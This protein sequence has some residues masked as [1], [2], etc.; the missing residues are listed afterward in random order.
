MTTGGKVYASKTVIDGSPPA[1]SVQLNHKS[2]NAFSS[3]SLFS[4]LPFCSHWSCMGWWFPHRPGHRWQTTWCRSY[5]PPW[6]IECV[7]NY[8]ASVKWFNE[9]A[10]KL[11]YLY[12][13]I[14]KVC[15]LVN[16]NQSSWTAGHTSLS[17]A[18]WE[19]KRRH[20]GLILQ[21]AAVYRTDPHQAPSLAQKRFDIPTSFDAR[22][23]WPNCLSVQEIRDQGHC[24]GCWVIILPQNFVNS[25]CPKHSSDVQ[26]LQLRFLEWNDHRVL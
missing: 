15:R 5:R 16:S 11:L 14:F 12:C 4:G 23:A 21:S 3:F 25:A 22:I 7:K 9:T 8:Q 18:T 2:R 13:L 1:V 10:V 26:K 6:K 24:A 20:T 19:E 17:G